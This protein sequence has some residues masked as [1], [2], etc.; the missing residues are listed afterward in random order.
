[1]ESIEAKPQ[2][3]IREAIEVTKGRY[4]HEAFA[5]FFGAQAQ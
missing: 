3:T 1:V 2:Y 5:A 4:G